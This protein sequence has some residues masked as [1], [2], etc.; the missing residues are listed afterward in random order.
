[1]I[2]VYDADFIARLKDFA[3]LGLNPFQIAERMDLEGEERR[4]FLCN[5]CQIKHP[6][7]L[8]YIEAGGHYREDM[9][10]ALNMLAATGDIDALELNFKLEWRRGI[11]QTKAE[12]FDL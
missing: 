5:I 12:L 8:A 1:M 4:Q 6:L 10:A 3:V 2:P 9:T 11:E 7:H